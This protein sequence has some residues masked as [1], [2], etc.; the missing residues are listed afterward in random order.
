[1][2]HVHIAYAN[3]MLSSFELFLLFTFLIDFLITM[4]HALLANKYNLIYSL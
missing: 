4:F 1:M 2:G 3:L